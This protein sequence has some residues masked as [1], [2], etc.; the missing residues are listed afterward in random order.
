VHEQVV[1][2]AELIELFEDEN[3]EK[4]I[5]NYGEKEINSRQINQQIFRDV[6]W[7]I[8]SVALAA[9]MLRVGSGSTFMTFAGIFQVCV[10]PPSPMPSLHAA[11]D[12]IAPRTWCPAHKGRQTCCADTL[13]SRM[14]LHDLPLH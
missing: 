14:C 2:A 4:I 13:P 1:V 5:I 7:A 6:Y 10:R 8:L 9:T 11:A 12:R 3:S